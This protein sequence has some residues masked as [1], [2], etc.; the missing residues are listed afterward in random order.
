MWN[1]ERTQFP[2]NTAFWNFLL[3]FQNA[4]FSSPV[5]TLLGCHRKGKWLTKGIY[6]LVCVLRGVAHVTVPQKQR[7]LTWAA[8]AGTRG[9]WELGVCALLRRVRQV[10]E[11]TAGPHL[12]HGHVN[13]CVLVNTPSMVSIRVRTRTHRHQYAPRTQHAHTCAR[14]KRRLMKVR[15]EFHLNI[16]TLM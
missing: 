12:N 13:A 1:C 9:L 15:T 2:R 16:P 6:E 7:E 4:Q 11:Q 10:R 8:P 5:C 14:T 3:S